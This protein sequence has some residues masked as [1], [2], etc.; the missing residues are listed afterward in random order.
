[1]P[2]FGPKGGLRAGTGSVRDCLAEVQRSRGPCKVGDAR[3][4]EAP[5][6]LERI[7]ADGVTLTV[8]SPLELGKGDQVDII[9]IVYDT[10]Y[11]APTHVLAVAASRIFL[12]LPLAIHLAERRKRSRGYLNIALL[13]LFSP[14][15]AAA[16][17]ESGRTYG[18]EPGTEAV[19]L[20]Q[21]HLA[22]VP[23]EAPAFQIQDLFTAGGT[24]APGQWGAYLHQWLESRT[25][26]LFTRRYAQN[27]DWS[28]VPA[29]PWQ[30]QHGGLLAHGFSFYFMPFGQPERWRGFAG[31]SSVRFELHFDRSDIQLGIRI[32]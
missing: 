25:Q 1:M 20:E 27:H 16:P 14:V 32:K 17:V 4:R 12:A 15:A 28:G 3:G 18:Y 13:G 24:A 26:S 8:D 19:A 6:G 22:A 2:L 9:F 7:A 21:F 29:P 11:K 5:A 10:R 31:F 30:R 23:S